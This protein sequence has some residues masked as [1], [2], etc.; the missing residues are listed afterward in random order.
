[1]R[2]KGPLSNR[3][4]LALVITWI[5]IVISTLMCDLPGDTRESDALLEAQENP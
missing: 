2:V 5:A 1:M 3:R 4:S